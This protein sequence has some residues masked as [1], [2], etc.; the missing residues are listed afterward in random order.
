M[1]TAPLSEEQQHHPRFNANTT[2]TTQSLNEQNLHQNRNIPAKGA[3][4]PSEKKHHHAV[5][6]P[7][8]QHL[9]QRNNATTKKAIPQLTSIFI[10]MLDVHLSNDTNF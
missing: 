7:R 8:K 5:P 2:R 6:L 9:H 3:R 10:N 1:T 4:L